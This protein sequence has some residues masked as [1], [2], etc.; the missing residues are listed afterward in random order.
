[1]NT[2]LQPHT[3]ADTGHIDIHNEQYLVSI[4]ET[5]RRLGGLSRTTVYKLI[6]NNDIEKVKIGARTMIIAESIKLYA[7]RLARQATRER[8]PQTESL[9]AVAAVRQPLQ[10]E[11]KPSN[12]A[13][14]LHKD[15]PPV[16]VSTAAERQ[17]AMG[18]IRGDR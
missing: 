18:R 6:E 9:T 10:Q 7:E 8:S 13:A 16:S 12:T 3:D 14:L 5:R 11:T 2:S 15:P 4:M 1:M 17:E